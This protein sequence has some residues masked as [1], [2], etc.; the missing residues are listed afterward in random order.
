M[1][2][3]TCQCGNTRELSKAT[4]VHR[5]GAWVTKEAECE[6]G[7]YMNSEPTEG[8]PTLKRTE[9]S[10]SNKSDKMWSSAAESMGNHNQ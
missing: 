8:I 9:N 3:Y 5:D 2:L 1:T 6:C 7:L 10:L 4:I